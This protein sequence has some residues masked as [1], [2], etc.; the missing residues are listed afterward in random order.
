MRELRLH[1]RVVK[2]KSEEEEARNEGVLRLRGE[3]VETIP[4]DV[5]LTNLSSTTT[6]AQSLEANSPELVVPALSSLANV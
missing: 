1:R 6:S 2:K 4:D 3:V 5:P